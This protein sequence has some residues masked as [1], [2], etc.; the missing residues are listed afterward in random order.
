MKNEIYTYLKN[1]NAV[2]FDNLHS[3]HSQ[4]TKSEIAQILRELEKEKSIV[5]LDSLYYDLEQFPIVQGYVNWNMNGFCWLDDSYKGNEYG[6]SFDLSENLNS[7]YNKREAFHGS[8]VIGRQVVVE[9]R[10]LVIVTESV[11]QHDIKCIATYS[12]SANNWIVINSSTSFTFPS[13]ETVI[14]GEI[15]LFNYEYA[16]QSFVYKEAIGNKQQ[17]GI[18]SDIVQR[19][20]KIDYAPQAVSEPKKQ[21]LP[22]STKPFYTIDSLYTK[23]IDD[24]IW[25]EKDDKG[26]H[27]WIAIADVSSFVFPNDEQDK[28]AQE[29]CTSFY[30]PHKTIH[31]LDR[32]LAENYCSLNVGNQR[33]A[34][35]CEMHFDTSGNMLS[36][37]F[38][39]Q[40]IMSKTRLTYNDVDKIVD[41]MYPSESLVYN[42][43][44]IEKF[45]D[46]LQNPQAIQ[47]LHV[48]QE[49]SQL[50]L[51]EQDR[52]YWINE[53]AE[54]QLNENGKISHLYP[55]DENTISQQMVTSAMLAANIAAAQFL[56]EK[57]PQ[58]GMFR[59][60]VKPLEN[61]NRPKPAFYNHENEGHWGLQTDFY[62]HFTS[63]IRRYCD[64]IVH[65]LIKNVIYSEEKTY[66][67]DELSKIAET[68]NL[69]QYKTKQCDIKTKN[70]LLNQY[71]ETLVKIKDVHSHLVITDVSDN[72]IVAR[73]DQL[74]EFFIPNFKLDKK[75]VRLV[76]SNKEKNNDVVQKTAFIASLNSQFN[77]E[78]MLGEFAWT[79]E[80]KN[81]MYQ[82]QR[83]EKKPGY[84][85][86]GR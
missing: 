72:G 21:Q 12:A 2:G 36:H 70:L 49:F 3:A 65:R 54:Y 6:I 59:N 81:G 18:E 63:P 31:M 14:D 24:A 44:S 45:N 79:D 23:D 78:M 39:Q 77:I 42:N 62:T 56:F 55:K 68:I 76:E 37:E 19:L 22:V 75:I 8:F 51:K 16:T 11:P 50:R 57:Y 46:V 27:L 84:Y 4:L 9:D 80:R 1:N 35:V 71:V 58:L 7:I 82:I 67:D 26:F 32:S 13:T 25:I 86:P 15:A 53:Q 48:L 73:N 30:L 33:S 17:N 40:S 5:Q 28:H 85:R 20:C 34:M 41:G 60:Q 10:S 47:S 29:K 83:I 64:L 61:E 43:G 38:Y 52:S 66:T 69:Q 74:L